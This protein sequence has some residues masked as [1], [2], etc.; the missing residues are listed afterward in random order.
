MKKW[1]I[2]LLST[3]CLGVCSPKHPRDGKHL[4]RKEQEFAEQLS[5]YKRRI[6][7]GQFNPKQRK[8]AMK[9]AAGAHQDACDTPDEAVIKV[10]EETGMSLAEKGRRRIE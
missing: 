7:C 2:I 6:F 4:P 1:L 8:M 3:T 10:M 9:Y 5:I